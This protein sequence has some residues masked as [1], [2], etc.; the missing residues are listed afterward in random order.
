MHHKLD[1]HPI[2][3]EVL[4]VNDLLLA[5]KVPYETKDVPM[6]LN[7]EGIM[8]RLYALYG[9]LGYPTESNESA[10]YSG[11]R[12]IITQLEIYDQVCGARKEEESVK[13]ANG[14]VRHSREGIELAGKIV[15]YLEENE[16]TAEC[17]PYD[18]VE[19]LREMFWL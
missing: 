18:E 15:K 17:F 4:Y 13:K 9:S 6:D 12:K 19:K 11:V 1:I 5:G 8:W 16:G 2:P 10:Y 3:E 14:G 7:A